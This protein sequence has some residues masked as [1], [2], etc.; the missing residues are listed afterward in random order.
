MRRLYRDRFDKKIAGIAGGFAQYFH[1]DSSIIRLL[2]IFIA[3]FTVGI[4]TLVYLLLWWIVPLGPKSYVSHSYKKFYRSRFNRHISGICGG[5]GK[6]FQVDPTMIRVVFVV[7][8]LCTG[9]TWIAIYLVGT[10]VIPQ[11][12]YKG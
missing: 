2:M 9:G 3:F 8:T 1:I 11:E 6:Y 5:L 10:F 4:F 12:P 7:L